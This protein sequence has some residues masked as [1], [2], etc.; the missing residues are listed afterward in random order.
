MAQHHNALEGQLQAVDA[1]LSERLGVLEATTERQRDVIHYLKVCL[2]QIVQ[3]K[4]E[5]PPPP[6]TQGAEAK[7]EAIKAESRAEQ[8]GK[9]TSRSNSSLE[10]ILARA[11]VMRQSQAQAKAAPSSSSS[12]S[13]AK[14]GTPSSRASAPTPAAKLRA[15]QDK[16]A[17]RDARITNNSS[18][19]NINN[20][21]NNSS[22]YSRS[23]SSSDAKSTPFSPPTPPPSHA[24]AAS[25]RSTIWQDDVYAQLSLLTAPSSS[26]VRAWA[27]GPAGCSGPAVATTAE[28]FAAQATL[29]TRLRRRDRGGGPGQSASR[30]VSGSGSG[31][32]SCSER[33]AV[34][35]PPSLCFLLVERERLRAAGVHGQHPQHK[36]EKGDSDIAAEASDPPAAPPPANLL[37]MLAQL[38]QQYDKTWRARL[39]RP[40]GQGQGGLTPHE[41]MELLTLWYRAHVCLGVYARGCGVDQGCVEGSAVPRPASSPATDVDSAHIAALLTE[42]LRPLPAQ[43]PVPVSRKLAVLCSGEW[44]QAARRDV[45]AFHAVVQGRVDFVLE[46]LCGRVLLKSLLRGLRVCADLQRDGVECRETWVEA[47]RAY[48]AVYCLLVKQGAVYNSCL[49]LRAKS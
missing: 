33:G 10:E 36:A 4:A 12:A 26:S 7:S 2:S 11:R 19:S 49:F 15:A 27:H 39:E 38:R 32:R 30:S 34:E 42:L 21:N 35:L 23:S 40:S 47:L 20:N 43:A 29:L 31:S 5:P 3:N 24:P 18:N 37:P 46:S 41:R 17:P 9:E 16:G 22:S 28:L 6:T 8:Q 1:L 48:Q 13:S 14:R 45:A 25:S 44:A